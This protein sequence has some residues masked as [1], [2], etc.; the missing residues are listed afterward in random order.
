MSFS[1]YLENTFWSICIWSKH[2]RS[3]APGIQILHRPTYRCWGEGT[4]LWGMPWSDK[5]SQSTLDIG[6]WFF[7]PSQHWWAW[8]KTWP[9]WW[10]CL[11][12]S[13]LKALCRSSPI[14]LFF[15]DIGLAWGQIS[16]LWQIMSRWIPSMSDGYQENKF[17]F[18]RSMLTMRWCL[19]LVRSLLSRV[20]VAV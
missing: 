11:S 2:P 4:R 14:F 16:N 10:S 5:C 15:C 19:W 7:L 17:A 12:T 9:I 6:R 1:P 3:L 8:W 18:L 20:H 13:S